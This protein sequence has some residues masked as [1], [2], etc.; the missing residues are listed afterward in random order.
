MILLFD[1]FGHKYHASQII[2]E[3]TRTPAVHQS[4]M[5]SQKT[6]TFEINT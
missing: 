1:I 2:L 3:I 5:L 6:V 4:A